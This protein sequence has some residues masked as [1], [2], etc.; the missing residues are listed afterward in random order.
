MPGASL[1]EGWSL[2]LEFAGPGRLLAVLGDGLWCREVAEGPW[3]P[4]APKA[5]PESL[6]VAVGRLQQARLRLQLPMALD[7]W[8]WEHEL[9]AALPAA[10]LVPRYLTDLPEISHPALLATP[11]VACGLAGEAHFALLQS[12]RVQQRPLVLLDPMLS[13][14]Q[15][16]AL[17]RYLRSHW[18]DPLL[19]LPD[20][21]SFWLTGVKGTEVTNASQLLPLGSFQA[22]GLLS[23]SSPE[24]N[25]LN[26]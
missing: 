13:S 23:F 2:T 7:A 3:P 14:T 26:M 18:R 8:P 10:R 11:L 24:S 9:V 22:V 1:T 20:L 6:S 25:S 12:A 19:L 4:N 15:R 17:E 5:L 21:L 16:L